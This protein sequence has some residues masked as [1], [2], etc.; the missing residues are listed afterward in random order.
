MKPSQKFQDFPKMKISLSKLIISEEN[1][2]KSKGFWLIFTIIY[3]GMLL[4]M[5]PNLAN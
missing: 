2:F 3:T 1:T 5:I 4:F